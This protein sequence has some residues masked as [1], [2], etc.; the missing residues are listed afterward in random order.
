[1]LI[2]QEKIP[3]LMKNAAS[4]ATKARLGV[5][6]FYKLPKHQ[7]PQPLKRA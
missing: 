3:I 7:L 5:S 1:M 4:Q 2:F 6:S